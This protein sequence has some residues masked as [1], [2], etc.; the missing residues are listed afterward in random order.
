M[1]TPTWIPLFSFVA[2]ITLRRGEKTKYEHCYMLSH[3]V[4]DTME[5]VKHHCQHDISDGWTV[6]MV[7]FTNYQFISGHIYIYYVK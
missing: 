5:T 6:I 4:N 7:R 1:Q 2:E 3:N